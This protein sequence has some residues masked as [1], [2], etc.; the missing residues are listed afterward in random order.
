M[1]APVCA[2]LD[3]LAV[4][5]AVLLSHWVEYFEVHWLLQVGEEAGYVATSVFVGCDYVLGGPVRPVQLIL[6]MG[7]SDLITTLNKN[8]QVVYIT[9]HLVVP[10]LAWADYPLII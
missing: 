7:K 6:E 8:F 2:V 9:G 1:I 5:G 4:I 10:V 3:H